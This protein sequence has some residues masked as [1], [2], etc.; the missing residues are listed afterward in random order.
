MTFVQMFYA[1]SKNEL[2]STMYY[3]R[4]ELITYYTLVWIVEQ[5]CVANARLICEIHTSCLIYS[6]RYLWSNGQSRWEYVMSS[7]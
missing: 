7:L 3:R 5:I 6:Q 1:K 4:L 2:E